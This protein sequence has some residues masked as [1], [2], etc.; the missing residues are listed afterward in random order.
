MHY[1]VNCFS[2]YLDD[3]PNKMLC[4]YEDALSLQMLPPGDWHCPHCSCKFCGLADMSF[5]EGSNGRQDAVLTC[6]LCEGKCKYRFLSF[7]INAI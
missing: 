6:N 3:K 4:S 2:D 7:F 5:A 1:V